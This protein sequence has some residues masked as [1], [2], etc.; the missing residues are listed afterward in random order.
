MT[1]TLEL[2]ELDE[3]LDDSISCDIERCSKIATFYRMHHDCIFLLCVAH[4][5]AT[6][7]V[8]TDAIVYSN[9]VDC[10]WCHT[11]D[12]P[13]KNVSILPL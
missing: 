10:M 3:L 9:F 2:I 8:I 6:H 12:I 1:D 5:E 13:P 11:V 4:K 7:K